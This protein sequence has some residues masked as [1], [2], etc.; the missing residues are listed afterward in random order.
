MPELKP[1]S[2]RISD[3]NYTRL[4]NLSEGRSLDE[5]ITYLLSAHDKDEERNSLGNQAVKLDELD[6]FLNAIRSQFASLLYTCQNVKEVIRVEYRK[7]LEDKN[8]TI[9]SMK[10]EILKLQKETMRK[11]ASAQEVIEQLRGQLEDK[12]KEHSALKAKEADYEKSIGQKQQ[13]IDSLSAALSFAEK[14]ANRLDEAETALANTESALKE[15]R[16]QYAEL[17]ED[18]DRLLKKTEDA[19]AII[20]QQKDQDAKI[21]EQSKA[22]YEEQLHKCKTDYEEQLTKCKTDCEKQLNQLKTQQE[23]ERKT[24]R[25]ESELSIKEAQ[26]QAQS[27]INEIKEEYQNKLF[28][29]MM[30]QS[31]M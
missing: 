16:I 6:E 31:N 15:L 24:L 27:R 11:D 23:I 14:K 26:I 19:A 8:I 7:E 10:D 13:T 5:T 30:S 29:L 17:K 20:Q 25:T 2:M 22:N 28:E 21:L 4:Q 3:D 1:R 12:R 9:D 18:R